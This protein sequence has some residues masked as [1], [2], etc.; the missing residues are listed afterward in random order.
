MRQTVRLADNCVGLHDCVMPAA[1]APEMQAKLAILT[2]FQRY[3]A[4]QNLSFARRGLTLL[5]HMPHPE[6][7]ASAEY[8]Q[9]LITEAELICKYI[10]GKPLLQ[11]L[12]VHGNAGLFNHQQLQQLF[13]LL[14]QHLQLPSNNFAWFSVEIQPGNSSWATLGMLR[15]NCF[16]R[17]TING[18]EPC[19][20]AAESLYEAA[21]ALQYNTVAM[22]APANTGCI[23]TQLQ[24]LR[25]IIR[26]QPDRIQLQLA[27]HT[28]PQLI[29]LLQAASYVR[30]ASDCFVL[31]D[32][33][34]LEHCDNDDASDA[35]LA[36]LGLGTG[37]CSQLDDLHY[38]NDNNLDA[39]IQA[40][41]HKQLPLARGYRQ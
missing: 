12:H 10:P 24:R 6:Q 36:V 31:P 28:P 2:P 7:P 38:C 3:R 29:D 19:F 16:N 5:L 4:I 11:Q 35:P 21:R 41:N 17:I 39:Y 34:L 13:A 9:A 8:Q 26:L 15:D 1:C 23:T 32:D 20:Q 30:A 25:S 14:R 33:E 18:N 22:A 27:E 40:L 37:A